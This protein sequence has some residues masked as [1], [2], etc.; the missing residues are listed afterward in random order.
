MALFIADVFENAMWKHDLE[1]CGDYTAS[2]SCY[3]STDLSNVADLV[4][5]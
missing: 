4:Q 1:L 5:H 2:V 3:F